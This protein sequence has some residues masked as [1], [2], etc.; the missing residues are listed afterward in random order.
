L[1]LLLLLL[2]TSAGMEPSFQCELKTSGCLQNKSSAVDG[3]AKA[4]SPMD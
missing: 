1:L 4:P 2:L 3:A